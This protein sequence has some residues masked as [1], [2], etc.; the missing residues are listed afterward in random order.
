MSRLPSVCLREVVGLA[1]VPLVHPRATVQASTAVRGGYGNCCL[2]ANWCCLLLRWGCCCCSHHLVGT[3]CLCSVTV[4]L[5]IWICGCAWW[6]T[7]YCSLPRLPSYRF[8]CA[9]SCSSS[10]SNICKSADSS[11]S[12]LTSP[13]LSSGISWA[14]LACGWLANYCHAIL[15]SS[16]ACS[17]RTKLSDGGPRGA[18]CGR[19]N[20]CRIANA[21]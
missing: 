3:I 18:S 4:E 14:S 11:A 13:C 19:P 16:M 5:G 1:V 15:S 17:S 7:I 20:S 9:S 2:P 12:Q 6:G 8:C 10:A 21:M